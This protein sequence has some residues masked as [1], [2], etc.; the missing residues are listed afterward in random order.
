MTNKNFKNG[1][2]NE[3]HTNKTTSSTAHGP[4]KITLSPTHV[5]FL[6]PNTKH[7]SLAHL[8]LSAHLPGETHT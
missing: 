7:N 1:M 3:I 4:R 2:V 5:T 6:V 8:S